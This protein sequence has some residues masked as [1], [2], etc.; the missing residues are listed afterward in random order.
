ML[1]YLCKFW[2]FHPRFTHVGRDVDHP[3]DFPNFLAKVGVKDTV[4]KY[5]ININLEINIRSESN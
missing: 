4:L 1:P 5:K 3:L 2:E